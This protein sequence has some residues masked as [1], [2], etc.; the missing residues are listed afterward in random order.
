M[1][2]R[3]TE[4][5]TRRA[6]RA[7]AAALGLVVAVLAPEPLRAESDTRDESMSD[8]WDRLTS[9]G[10]RSSDLR[11]RIAYSRDEGLTRDGGYRMREAIPLET[12]LEQ[13]R[14]STDPVVLSL[15]LDRCDDA[16]R[17]AGRCDAV[18][19]AHRWT[20]ADTQNQLAWLALSAALAG[21]GDADGARTTF[22]RAAEASHWHEHVPETERALVA[23][24]P[25][26]ADPRQRA[27]LLLAVVAKALVASSSAYFQTVNTRCKDDD[28]KDACGRILEVMARDASSLQTLV[29]AAT[30]A[31]D[32]STLPW[33]TVA[34]IRQRADAM[35]WAWTL[36]PESDLRTMTPDEL[37]RA[38]AEMESLIAR[39]EIETRRRALQRAGLVESEAA[40]RYVA[41]LGPDELAR[42]LPRRAGP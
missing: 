37:T 17:K 10:R 25:T 3:G 7:F 36:T 6:I 20:V 35:H 18:D 29:V 4:R 42:R 15:M 34:A 12:L 11:V 40:R 27:A 1:R 39:G 38:V 24:A 33:A 13:A 28:A 23:A 19:L 14:G 22:R 21:R 16:S 5:S 32:R 31:R 26:S 30:L 2:R 8:A 41:T 9:L